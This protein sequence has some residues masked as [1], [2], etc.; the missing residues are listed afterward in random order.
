MLITSPSQ[1]D[2][3]ILHGVLASYRNIE[4]FILQSIIFVA[5]T[6]IVGRDGVGMEGE[7]KG[8]PERAVK[9]RNNPLISYTS[10]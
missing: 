4:I 5:I 9:V 2:A 6:G 3:C 10:L 7:K 8:L 1:K